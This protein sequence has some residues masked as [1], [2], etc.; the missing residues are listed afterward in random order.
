MMF[1]RRYVLY[2]GSM[3]IK[4]FRE[5]ASMRFVLLKN[6]FNSEFGPQCFECSSCIFMHLHFG[7]PV[8]NLNT[9]GSP[10]KK[11]LSKADIDL[12]KHSRVDNNKAGDYCLSFLNRPNKKNCTFLFALLWLQSKRLFFL[13]NNFEDFFSSP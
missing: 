13:P 11:W 10:S 7:V 12:V 3:G 8:T 9:F 6:L 1:A 5:S 4:E 2:L